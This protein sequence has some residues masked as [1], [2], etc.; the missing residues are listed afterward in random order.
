MRQRERVE[1]GHALQAVIVRHG[2]TSNVLR[3]LMEHEVGDWIE[4]DAPKEKLSKANA[5]SQGFDVILTLKVKG[6]GCVQS[7]LTRDLNAAGN[8]G[9]RLVQG[10]QIGS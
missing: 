2:S 6:C 7:S 9:A 8:L 3:Q 10:N 1:A 5:I 4:G